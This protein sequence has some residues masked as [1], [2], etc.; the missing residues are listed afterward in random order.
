MF[1]WLIAT[2]QPCNFAVLIQSIWMQG[3]DAALFPLQRRLLV[4]GF[5]LRFGNEFLKIRIVAQRV[6][7]ERGKR[8][9]E[10]PGK[11]NALHQI[12]K[13]PIRTDG[14]ELRRNVQINEMERVLRVRFFQ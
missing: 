2:L 4:N 7:P 13:S 14:F 11:A 1:N 5:R 3:E 12:L 10:L 8:A 6:R 9:A